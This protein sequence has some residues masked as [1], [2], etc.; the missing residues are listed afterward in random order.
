MVRTV[1]V[2]AA[3]EGLFAQAE[4]YVDRLFHELR[5]EPE[6]GTIHVGQQRYV[7]IRGESLYVALFDQL[8]AAFGAEQAGEFIYNL[9][10]VIGRADSE[11][12]AKERGITDPTE[13]LS[14]GPV[15]FAYAGWAF[16][17][18]LPTSR[19]APD[20]SYFLHYRHP[21]TFESEIVRR[22]GTRAPEPVCLFSAGY[23]A[24]W[25]SAA[26]GIDVHAREVLC[27]GRGD[28]R[29]EFIMAPYEALDGLAAE[30]RRG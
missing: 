14:T 5:R 8:T 7:L 24:G 28:D 4:T 21:N 18:I 3:F 1:S 30:L 2:P 10:R 27:T 29:C 19:P 23:S 25:C 20:A 22:R 11:S 6:R 13:R 16:V 26:Y 17:D 12:F 9:A 15:H